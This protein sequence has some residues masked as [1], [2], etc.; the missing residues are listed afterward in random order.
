MIGL[1]LVA[2]H[3]DR[4]ARVVVTNTGL[5]TGDQ[6]MGDAF[7]SWQRFSQES[8][9]FPVGTIV[10]AACTT[11]LDT[12]VMAAYDAPFPDDRYKTGPRAFPLL[13]PMR[14]DDPAS[15]ANRAAWEVLARWDRPLLTAFSDGD[16]ITRGSNRLFESKVPGAHGQ[17][18]TIIKGA[19]HFLQ[20]DKGPELAEAIVMFV[21][22]TPAE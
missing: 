1:R 5:P 20:E 16:P 19:G 9:D 10:N 8:P 14:P 4:F 13:V 3:P 11:V 7:L 18:H 6:P 21:A 17:P 15:S 12:A 22:S 2:E